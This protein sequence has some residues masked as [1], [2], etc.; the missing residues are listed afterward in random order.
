MNLMTDRYSLN[1]LL[2]YFFIFTADFTKCKIHIHYSA[3]SPSRSFC[4]IPT[5]AV[6]NMSHR[7]PMAQISSVLANSF[8]CRQIIQAR[9][10]VTLTHWLSIHFIR[11][12]HKQFWPQGQCQESHWWTFSCVIPCLYLFICHLLY[13]IFGLHHPSF[14]YHIYMA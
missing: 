13:V 7:N 1:Y 11:T 8:T 6:G 2:L 10:S 14:L 9:L 3:G 5:C 4:F 12:E